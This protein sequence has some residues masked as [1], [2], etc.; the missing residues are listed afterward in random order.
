[1]V[2]CNEHSS[3]SGVSLKVIVTYSF[4]GLLPRRRRRHQAQKTK[5]RPMPS[6]CLGKGCSL[7]GAG[8]Y[9]DR[10]FTLAVFFCSHSCCELLRGRT[11]AAGK[12]SCSQTRALKKISK[13]KKIIELFSPLYQSLLSFFLKPALTRNNCSLV[14]AWHFDSEY[15]N[16]YLSVIP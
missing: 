11:D 15:F 12:N 9:S 14:F 8:H 10:V 1:M 3:F 6:S 2:P 4:K 5:P 7:L 13:K 16:K